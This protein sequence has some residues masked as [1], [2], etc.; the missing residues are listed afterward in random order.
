MF[1]TPVI[2]KIGYRASM[3]VSNATVIAG[4]LLLTVLP[5]RFSNPFIGIL[6][7]VCI[8]AVGGGIQEVLV[9]PIV[10][11]CPSKNKETQMSLL[12]STYCW[13]HLSVVLLS[14]F[15]FATVGI[16]NWRLLAVLW[17]I[18]PAIDL[19]L[20]TQVPIAK[21]EANT[22]EHVGVKE[23]F[24]QKIFW[25]MFIMM[26]CAGASEQAVSQWSSTLAEKGLG[27]SKTLGDLLGPMFF[28]FCMA[29]S[30][31][32]Y[33]FKGH[34]IN[35][36]LFMGISTAL[37]IAAYLIIVLVPVPVIALL[38][39]GLVGFS[40]GIF[41]PGT[42]S[43]ASAMVNGRGTLL[44]ALLALA[45]DLGCSGGP[46]LVGTVASHFNGNLK[47][48]MGAAIVFPVIMGAG[49]LILGLYSPVENERK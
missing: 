47:S 1:S 27:I 48:G 20:F 40:V 35:L 15:F 16:E 13:G 32:I 22:E 33:G 42:F 24:S 36:R 7:S 41:W 45:G 8:Y 11:A 44:F 2:E 4:L 17:C 43:T 46:T 23:L 14:T 30:R 26:L 9:S 3:I 5:G 38:G 34:K 31:T 49:L 37:C 19:I 18:V 29:I 12:H 39:C 10:E 21:L 6:M 28:A 25:L